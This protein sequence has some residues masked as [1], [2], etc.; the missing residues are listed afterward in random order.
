MME[1][2]HWWFAAKHR[3]VMDLLGRMLRRVEGARARAR[4]ADLG[5]GCGMLLY[6][7]K[8]KY[9][10]VGVDGSEKAIEFCAVRGV[11]VKLGR[12]AA[13]AKAVA[14]AAAASRQATMRGA[15]VISVFLTLVQALEK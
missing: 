13:A 3:I 5:C 12:A 14:G 10:V 11:P 8:D 6:K 4:V 15:C 7:L 2:R 1:Q 9:D